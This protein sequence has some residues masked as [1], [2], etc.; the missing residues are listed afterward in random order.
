VTSWPTVRGSGPHE[1]AL[2][3]RH[4]RRAWKLLAGPGPPLRRARLMRLGRG[5][6][7]I[8]RWEVISAS[9]LLLLFSFPP[10]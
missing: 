2:G 10:A 9:L 5:H 3:F 4:R 8:Q 7:L 6:G 1:R